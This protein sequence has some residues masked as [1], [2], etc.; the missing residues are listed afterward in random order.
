[1]I[2]TIYKLTNIVNRKVYIGY[3]SLNPE[4]R[5][6]QHRQYAF[7]TN[8]KGKLLYKAILKHGVESF[9]MEVIYQSRDREHAL[10]METHFITEYRSWVD[11]PDARGYN[12]T[13]GG[14]QALKS[15]ATRDAQA[16][17][18]RGRPQTAE[19]KAKKGFSSTN[20][21]E[22]HPFLGRKH[23][24]EARAKM[25]TSQAKWN[26]QITGPNGIE[27]VNNLSQFCRDKCIDRPNLL[28]SSKEGKLY[29]GYSAVRIG[30]P[31]HSMDGVRLSKEVRASSGAQ[32]KKTYHIRDIY[33]SEYDTDDL[34]AFALIHKFN[35]DS[36]RNYS[37][38][39]EYLKGYFI[40][41][42]IDSK[43][44]KTVYGQ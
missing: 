22:V 6:A 43:G 19:H 17:K 42:T 29:G 20:Q 31:A 3:T 35:K 25:S 9:T 5:F 12:L 16:A 2:Y 1:M 33:G 26:W 14:R 37:R 21:P 39:G 15:Q 4:K 44:R 24:E 38:R 28:A 7:N 34:P 23:N 40:E 13:M 36:I 10:D 11:F 30:G 41:Y 18:L 8:H 32:N 27:Q